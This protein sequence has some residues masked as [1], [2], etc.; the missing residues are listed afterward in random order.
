MLHADAT[1][2]NIM[3]IN[4]LFKIAL[5]SGRKGIS[6]YKRIAGLI[7]HRSQNAVVEL[8]KALLGC[9]A[10]LFLQAKEDLNAEGISAMK[11]HV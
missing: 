5:H 1:E 11:R 4:S 6:E 7:L 3:W 9:L 2:S 8:T 10:L